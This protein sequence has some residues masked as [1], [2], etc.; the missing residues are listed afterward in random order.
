MF[1]LIPVYI[2]DHY[3]LLYQVESRN[4]SNFKVE[5]DNTHSQVLREMYEY[6]FSCFSPSLLMLGL[7][8]LHQLCISMNQS[9]VVNNITRR[10]WQL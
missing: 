5:R 10:H 8:I 7:W 2:I 6:I 4:T 1:S 3:I 9:N